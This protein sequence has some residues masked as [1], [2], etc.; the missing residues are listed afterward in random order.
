MALS[1]STEEPIEELQ[2]ESEY[3]SLELFEQSHNNFNAN[4]AMALAQE[5][6]NYLAEL[7]TTIDEAVDTDINDRTAWSHQID[8]MLKVL[9]ITHSGSNAT[10]SGSIE[11]LYTTASKA[12][13]GTPLQLLLQLY[14]S[15]ITEIFPNTNPVKLRSFVTGNMQLDEHKDKMETFMNDFILERC[16]E[17]E[18]V[19]KK[20]LI[21]TF[22]AGSA[23]I[24]VFWNSML[25]RPMVELI[26]PK[27]LIISENA[28]SLRTASRV[29]HEYKLT[30]KELIQRQM[31][32]L[33]RNIDVTP[34]SEGGVF[35]D[36]DSEIDRLDGRSTT[37]N[38][39]N[40]ELSDVYTVRE[41][42]V[43]INLRR[44]GRNGVKDDAP[45][46]IS[47]YIVTY[48]KESKKVLAVYRNW[49]EGDASRTKREYI[50]KFSYIPGFGF[51]D[52]G[53]SHLILNQAIDSALLSRQI[54]NSF[55]FKLF[56]GGIRS[57]GIMGGQSHDLKPRPGQFEAVNLHGQSIA[58]TFKFFDYPDPS[59]V[60]LQLKEQNELSMKEIVGSSQISADQVPANMPGMTMLALIEEA[61]KTQN[62][63]IQSFHKSL[64]DVYKLIWNLFGQ[65]LPAAPQQLSA[66]PMI[67][68]SGHDFLP[69]LSA[70]PSSDPNVSSRTQRLA[71]TQILLDMSEK[72]PD[73]INR[74]ALVERVLKD[75]K[76][77]NPELILLPDQS[78]ILPADP[79][80]ENMN[81]LKGMGAQASLDQDHAAHIQEHML[82][83]NDP[84][85]GEDVKTIAK[86]HIQEHMA[87]QM[88]VQIQQKT[89]MPLPTDGQPLPVNIQNE[90][91]QAILPASQQLNQEM[92]QQQQAM[93]QQGQ[94]Q[95]PDPT[96][97]MMADVEMKAEANRMK[98][99]LE[100][101]K[102]KAKQDKEL[103]ETQIKLKELNIK[104]LITQREMNEKSSKQQIELYKSQIQFL[105]DTGR[106]P[107]AFPEIAEPSLENTN[108]TQLISSQE[109]HIPEN[110]IE[111][112][113]AQD[114]VQQLPQEE[115]NGIPTY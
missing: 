95:E 83:M 79:L 76:V 14:A 4:L 56:P 38:M 67:T 98:N 110:P 16:P 25:K 77:E 112:E 13:S 48:L 5:N 10:D 78:E 39:G 49:D 21:W 66:N 7:A 29:V 82:L 31:T 84:N 17:F 71:R 20:T 70:I 102:L 62:T 89:D 74:R 107:P 9:N 47:P 28:S 61:S 30:H 12:F 1:V 3:P 113:S 85:V 80:T 34:D 87:D 2:D 55:T 8:T 36:D 108:D 51:V 59:P 88:F 33:Y 6:E 11:D 63:I 115:D 101:I 24:K 54:I 103:L 106:M 37:Q 104:E 99:E 96:Q 81:M 46:D 105:R 60:S 22:L 23:Y 90:I 19:L 69:T 86:A 50:V 73:Q 64:S 68:V 109:T 58:E 111:L 100:L 40:S 26:R 41:C 94:P 44:F 93:M 35:D 18:S 32:G 43:D 91:A 42:Y 53:L 27:D 52:Y 65:Y 114:E 15:S 92:L 57:K 72:F 45:K 97:A 75:T